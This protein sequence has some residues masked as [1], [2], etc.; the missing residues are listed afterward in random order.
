MTALPSY[1]AQEGEMITLQCTVYVSPS[2]SDPITWFWTCD[3]KDF[4]SNSTSNGDTSTVTFKADRKLNKKLCFCRA[5]ANSSGII[6]N[7]TSTYKNIE[8]YYPPL[9]SPKLNAYQ[10]E[11]ATGDDITLQCLIDSLGNPPVRWSWKCGTQTINSRITNI[12]L[13]SKVVF[14]AD[15]NLNGKSCYCQVDA[16]SR[17]DFKASSS[18]ADVSVFYYPSDFPRI[19]TRTVRVNVGSPVILHCSLSSA[20]NPQITWSWY[21]NDVIM[22]EDVRDR[23]TSTELSFIAKLT[24][25]K[26]DCYCRGRSSHPLIKGSYDQKSSSSYIKI[27]EYQMNAEIFKESGSKGISPAAFGATLTILLIALISC[28]IIIIIQHRRI[29]KE[30]S[31]ITWFLVKIGKARKRKSKSFPDVQ[32]EIPEEHSYETLKTGYQINPF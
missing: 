24:D 17:Y 22:R 23:D 21:C 12:G 13:A 3:D 25:D 4:K 8:V 29:P 6:Y 14:E 5:T 1:A 15:P 19:S 10:I 16:P 27:I 31:L 30:S 9:T 2:D 26:T 7:S 11:K 28:T 18:A 20:G 32:E